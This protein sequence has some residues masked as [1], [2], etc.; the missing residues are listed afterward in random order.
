MSRIR[1]LCR[2]MGA[3]NGSTPAGVMVAPETW[4]PEICDRLT[5]LVAKIS[6]KGQRTVVRAAIVVGG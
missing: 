4:H 6:Q 2:A 5:G 3:A 1:Q